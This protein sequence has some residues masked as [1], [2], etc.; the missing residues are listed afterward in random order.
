MLWT[1]SQRGRAEIK[2]GGGRRL[3]TKRRDSLLSMQRYG[4]VQYVVRVRNDDDHE[5]GAMGEIQVGDTTS[6]YDYSLTAKTN[7]NGVGEV[8]VAASPSSS[9][10]SSS[11]TLIG[12][13]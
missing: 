5:I 9:S 11:F 13:L 3:S 10:S 8:V 12:T 6:F 4:K 2:G 7:T 1:S